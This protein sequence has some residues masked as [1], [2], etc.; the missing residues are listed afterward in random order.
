[1]AM[2]NTPSISLWRRLSKIGMMMVGFLTI[3]LVGPP[4]VH[5]RTSPCIRALVLNPARPTTLY[6]GTDHGGIFDSDDAGK[7]WHSANHGLTDL[8]S[9][10]VNPSTGEV[11]ATGYAANIRVIATSPALPTTVYVGTDGS[12]VFRSADEGRTWSP[13][14]GGLLGWLHITALAIHPAVP[15][16]LYAGTEG[17]V[18]QSKDSGDSWRYSGGCGQPPCEI[19]AL[20]IDPLAPDTVYAG[21]RGSD[22]VGVYVTRD[23]G[24]SWHPARAGLETGQSLHYWDAHALAINTTTPATLYART[25]GGIFRSTDAGNSWRKLDS[26]PRGDTRAILVDPAAAATLYIVSAPDGLFR[27]VDGG[28]TWAPLNADPPARFANAMAIDP[29]D[30]TKLYLGTDAGVLRS[31]DG[32]AHWSAAN[33]GLVDETVLKD[34]EGV[35]R[36]TWST[37]SLNERAW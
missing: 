2:H 22:L 13:V 19:A 9:T 16:T 35:V 23:A 37:R 3:A 15:T 6:A 11:F 33:V 5:A 12:G 36:G 26:G 8:G 4:E 7:T 28:N 24:A 17:G 32:G 25:G 29:T 10:A 14:N 27:S 1:M 34:T 21:G 20:A 18:Y 31:T 30:S